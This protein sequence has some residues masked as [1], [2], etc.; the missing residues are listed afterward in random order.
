MN[1][2]II[3]IFPLQFETLV[4]DYPDHQTNIDIYLQR[5]ED[6]IA[7]FE[8]DEDTKLIVDWLDENYPPSGAAAHFISWILIVSS[9][10]TIWFKF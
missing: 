1:K 2:I 3:T 9:I 4:A 10:M 8:A 7:A 5:I 6:N